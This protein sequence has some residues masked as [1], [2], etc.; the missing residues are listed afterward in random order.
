MF[1]HRSVC[2]RSEGKESNSSCSSTSMDTDNEDEPHRRVNSGHRRRLSSCLPEKEQHEEVL[3]NLLLHEIQIHT[4]FLLFFFLLS[5][6]CSLMTLFCLQRGGAIESAEFNGINDDEMLA[7]VLEMSRREACHPAPPLLD[8][9]PTSSPDTG[10]GDTDAHDLAY[11][12]DLMENDGKQ[13]AGCPE[14]EGSFRTLSDSL[15]DNYH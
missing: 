3:R 13:S 12:A 11:H 7:A 9:D 2:R 14:T 5:L 15:F 10:F 6:C 1:K 4:P 8:D